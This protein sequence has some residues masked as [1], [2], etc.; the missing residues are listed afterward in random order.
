MLFKKCF[1]TSVNLYTLPIFSFLR[2][3]EFLLLDIFAVIMYFSLKPL[4][5][6]LLTQHKQKSFLDKSKCFIRTFS[7]LTIIIIQQLLDTPRRDLVYNHD[8]CRIHWTKN[9]RLFILPWGEGDFPYRKCSSC[10]IKIN[11]NACCTWAEPRPE[12][13][14]KETVA[15]RER[16]RNN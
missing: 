14:K 2:F 9:N 16:H 5:C 12:T 8:C 6:S 3:Y 15:L 4:H 11:R 13:V 7:E 10:A 1:I